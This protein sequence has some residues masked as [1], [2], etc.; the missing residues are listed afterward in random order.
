[1]DDGYR[2][3]GGGAEATWQRGPKIE[4]GKLLGFFWRKAASFRGKIKQWSVKKI[5]E[6]G[7]KFSRWLKGI[8]KIL[9]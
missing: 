5:E 2:S 6:K 8:S 7:G 9:Y 4:G 3:F 1:M